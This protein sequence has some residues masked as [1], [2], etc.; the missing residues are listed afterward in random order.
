M[1][2]FNVEQRGASTL[3]LIA[4]EFQVECGQTDLASAYVLC[5]LNCRILDFKIGGV[6]E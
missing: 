5:P 2:S 1:V 4:M 3:D 6:M